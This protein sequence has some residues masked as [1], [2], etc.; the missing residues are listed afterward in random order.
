VARILLRSTD[1][2]L[3]CGTIGSVVQRGRNGYL[4]PRHGRERLDAV[5]GAPWILTSSEELAGGP[6][7]NIN[8]DL[9]DVD[10][11]NDDA[12]HA[13]TF[14][15]YAFTLHIVDVHIVDVHIVDKPRLDLH[16]S[17]L[18]DI[19]VGLFIIDNQH[20][21]PANPSADRDHVDD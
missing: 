3:R 5:V 18:N 7:H 2:S 14:N 20:D 4:G 8:V 12:F 15:V 21:V 10:L 16:L 13:H 6:D 1:L 9:I 17:R 11:I 19:N